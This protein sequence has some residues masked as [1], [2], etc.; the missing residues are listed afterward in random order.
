VFGFKHYQKMDPLS[1][2]GGIVAVLQTTD[3]LLGLVTKLRQHLID[4]PSEVSSLSNEIVDFRLL[5]Q[6]FKDVVEDPASADLVSEKSE[7][8]LANLIQDGQ[9]VCLQLEGILEGQI[10]RNQSQS[11]SFSRRRRIAWLGKRGQVERLKNRLREARMSAS[12]HIV[13]LSL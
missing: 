9:N 8:I 2:V 12:S 5:F 10:S 11:G 4:A 13:G 6:N 7:T 1:I 3:R